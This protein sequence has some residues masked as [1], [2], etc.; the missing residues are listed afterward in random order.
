L[1][2]LLA[3]PEIDTSDVIQL[4]Q[5][6]AGKPTAHFKHE[7][8]LLQ[9]FPDADVAALFLHSVVG[10]WGFAVY[11]RGTLIRH[12]HASEKD[13]SL[14]LRGLSW[15]SAAKSFSGPPSSTAGRTRIVCV[16]QPTCVAPQP[17]VAETNYLHSQP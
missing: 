3:K 15:P 6:K 8:P 2:L 10:A 12:Q 7:S 17:M 13:V 11:R 14:T 4:V 1:L 9:R 5:R 16:F